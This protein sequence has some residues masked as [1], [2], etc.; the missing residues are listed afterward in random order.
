MIRRRRIRRM[1]I[2]TNSLMTKDHMIEIVD[3]VIEIRKVIRINEVM[4]P[5]VTA[6]TVQVD[7]KTTAT[8]VRTR[9]AMTRIIEA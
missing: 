9:N 2:G 7:S 8:K 1:M 3:K 4:E 5:V 6:E